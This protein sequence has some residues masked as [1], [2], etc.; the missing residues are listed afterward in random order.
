VQPQSYQVVVKVMAPDGDYWPLPW[1]LRRFK[2]VGW[3]DH[4][5]LDPDA[6]IMI[7]GTKFGAALGDRPGQTWAGLYELRPLN[8]LEL[9]VDSALWAQYLKSGLRPSDE[10]E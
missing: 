3:W 5:P 8:F 2:H 6:P 4:V 9:R 1:Y 7:A 10:D